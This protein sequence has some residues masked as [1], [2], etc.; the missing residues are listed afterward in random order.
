MSIAPSLESNT[1]TNDSQSTVNDTI[2]DTN[3]SSTEIVDIAKKLESGGRIISLIR[4]AESKH[5]AKQKTLQ[6]LIKK[7]ISE[8]KVLEAYTEYY[9]Q[10][11]LYEITFTERPLGFSVIMDTRGKNAIVSSVQNESNEKMGLKVASR[12]YNVNGKCVE[13][14]KYKDILKLISNQQLPFFVV[15]RQSKKKSK[16]LEKAK[17]KEL[18][19][20]DE[21]EISKPNEDS[22]SDADS[23]ESYSSDDDEAHVAQHYK[24][25]KKKSPKGGSQ[26]L[27]KPNAIGNWD[28]A[29]VD[30]EQREML[31]ELSRLMVT[32]AQTAATKNEQPDNDESIKNM[33]HKRQATLKKILNATSTPK[34]GATDNSTTHSMT[35]NVNDFDDD[36]NQDY[37]PEIFKYMSDFLGPS[38]SIASGRG[39]PLTPSTS[40]LMRDLFKDANDDDDTSV[41]GTEDTYTA[42]TNGNR[43]VITIVDDVNDF[44]Q[45]QNNDDSNGNNTNNNN[46]NDKN[47]DVDEKEF[48]LDDDLMNTLKTGTTMMKYGRYGKPKFKVFQLTPDH[49]Y[50]VWF[51]EKKDV[52]D[53]R[54][55]IKEIQKILIASE[56]KAVQ[57]VKNKELHE[58][59]FTILYGPSSTDEKSW[60]QLTVSA[61]NEKEAFV[62]AQGLK[63]LSDAAKKG[64][65][66]KDIKVDPSIATQH[67]HRKTQSVI[68]SM[69]QV[70][71]NSF[72]DIFSKRDDTSSIEALRKQHLRLKEQ[73]KKCA[74]YVMTKSNYKAIKAADQFDNVK[75]RIEDLETRLQDVG[76]LLESQ[77][78]AQDAA[79]IK[80]DLFSVNA[81]LDALK[82]KLT[83]LTRIPQVL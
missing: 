75:N 24:R 47:N 72:V 57:K 20:K 55:P 31:K 46:V 74:D 11:R 34:F 44:K 17:K 69:D 80:A 68:I 62:W 56:S 53:T 1:I 29:D 58:T 27:F 59:S 9:K 49:Q 7:G 39:M 71:R 82:Q 41:Q 21:S 77:N 33:T 8:S 73:L 42:D 16:K 22:G 60:K 30:K 15:F 51:S 13:G 6:F 10:E 45:S 76:K 79:G 18:G 35:F 2:T 25:K 19:W 43:D 37:D 38:D 65:N 52:Q 23:T 67:K 61:Q 28:E 3:T 66:I 54:I 40:L 14:M 64:T 5:V 36:E 63:I 12:I 32:V 83:A 78:V 81:D 50:L 48:A 70:N 4:K 26:G